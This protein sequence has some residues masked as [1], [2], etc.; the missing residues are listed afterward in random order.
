MG[1]KVSMTLW[2]MMNLW[3]LLKV[4]E[5]G[6]LPT[7]A[8]RVH[9]YVFPKKAKWGPGQKGER[10][11]PL[12]K[13]AVVGIPVTG[14]KQIHG[15]DLGFVVVARGGSKD[16]NFVSVLVV[17]KRPHHGV[18]G[19]TPGT[20]C[21]SFQRGVFVGP[22]CDIS[23]PWNQCWGHLLSRHS[24]PVRWLRGEKPREW[25]RWVGVLMG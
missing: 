24:K 21:S 19:L 7:T 14:H 9:I 11:F 23:S 6:F 13:E 3:V 4:E 16:P 12:S 10:K 20:I 25:D 15:G 8:T 18:I 22:L 5:R 17:A 1:L 2:Q